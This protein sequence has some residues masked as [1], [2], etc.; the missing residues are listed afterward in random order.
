MACEFVV[1]GTKKSLPKAMRNLQGKNV[2]TVELPPV[3]AISHVLRTSRWAQYVNQYGIPV[4]S[5]S[6]QP[7]R[8]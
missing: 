1:Q 2:G 4:G 5:L 8:L 7:R 6:S 3:L